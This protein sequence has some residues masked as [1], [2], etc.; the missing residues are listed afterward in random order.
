MGAGVMGLVKE[1]VGDRAQK[2]ELARSVERLAGRAAEASGDLQTAQ[3]AYEGSGKTERDRAALAGAVETYN[4]RSKHLRA[5]LDDLGPEATQQA[6]GVDTGAL[7]K[8][9][10]LWRQPGTFTANA[11]IGAVNTLQGMGGFLLNAPAKLWNLDLADES[12]WKTDYVRPY[13]YDDESLPNPGAARMRFDPVSLDDAV[14]GRIGSARMG[15]GPGLPPAFPEELA[16]F[17]ARGR[18]ADP[19][20]Q[21]RRD[22]MTHRRDEQRPSAREQ[23]RRMSFSHQ[24]DMRVFVNDTAVQASAVTAPTTSVLQGVP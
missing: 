6:L 2:E 1:L 24:I 5:R 16:A 14:A 23:I 3:T 11:G 21:A 15:T 20:E 8:L 19:E 10:E 4:R 9:R 7:G 22:A 13:A 18:G 12:I 17:A